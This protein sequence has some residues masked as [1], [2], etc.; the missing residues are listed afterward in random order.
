MA[1]WNFFSTYILRQAPWMIGF[2]TMIGY[3][4]LKK[5]FYY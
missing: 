3:I 4:L 2:I 5:N 1:V